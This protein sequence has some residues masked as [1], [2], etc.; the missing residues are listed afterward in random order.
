[1]GAFQQERGK[2]ASPEK[3][4]KKEKKGRKDG[5]PSLFPLGWEKKKGKRSPPPKSTR[6]R[7]S[8]EFL[9]S[10]LGRAGRGKKGNKTSSPAYPEDKKERQKN[11][12]KL[13]L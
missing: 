11:G 4:V 8:R 6:E 1:V 5:T 9:S 10:A 12:E 2:E 13:F 7:K 3:P